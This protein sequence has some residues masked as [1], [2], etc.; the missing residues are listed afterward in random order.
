LKKFDSFKFASFEKKKTSCAGRKNMMILGK[1]ARSKNKG[2]NVAMSNFKKR[3]KDQNGPDSFITNV[4]A[5]LK[6]HNGQTI[7]YLAS[8]LI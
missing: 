8:Q 3:L 4:Q 5:T 2:R 1:V 6:R 7:S